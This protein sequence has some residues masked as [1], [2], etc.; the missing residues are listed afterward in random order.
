MEKAFRANSSKGKSLPASRDP[1]PHFNSWL[2]EKKKHRL[3]SVW[4]PLLLDLQ[5]VRR[6][7]PSLS[8]HSHPHALLPLYL[9]SVLSKIH[10]S[11]QS[12]FLS[13]LLNE[14]DQLCQQGMKNLTDYTNIGSEII[15]RLLEVQSFIKQWTKDKKLLRK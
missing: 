10:S 12:A 13:A 9:V 5:Q 2:E 3:L 4:N 6:K 11:Y 1:R 8:Q 7:L 15:T 14:A